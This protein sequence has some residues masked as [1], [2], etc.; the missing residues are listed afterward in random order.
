MKLQKARI[1]KE[2]LLNE[3]SPSEKMDIYEFYQSK[4]VVLSKR[5]QP[6][7]TGV[8]QKKTKAWEKKKYTA[9]TKV[10]GR[11][12]SSSGG[13]LQKPIQYY[14]MWYRYLQLALE[15]AEKGVIVVTKNWG[16]YSEVRMDTRGRE[17]QT[18]RIFV[19][20]ETQKVKVDKKFYKEWD[21]DRVIT[22]TFDTW[23]KGHRELF[24][25]PLPSMVKSSEVK[26]GDGSIYLKI[27]K[28]L[29]PDELQSHIR[30]MVSPELN[31]PN[32]Y[33]IEGRASYDRLLRS[34]NAFTCTLSGL[35][36]KE[37]VLSDEGYLRTPDVI[38]TTKKTG[39]KM[40]YSAT[41]SPLYKE[42]VFHMLEVAEGRFGKG[43]TR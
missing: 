4:G 6:I 14:R 16:S 9:T 26:D 42:G 38:H 1:R 28:R 25:A 33:Q 36:P 19:P 5:N 13:R 41:V 31:Q 22:S 15:L 3:A 10:R 30:S 29:S 18:R 40:K 11:S 43:F 20:R 35:S 2:K 32:K 12:E 21:L 27:D 8:V 7:K 17:D 37:I 24:E 34:Y 39:D 23:W